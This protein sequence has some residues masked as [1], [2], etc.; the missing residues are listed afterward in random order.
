MAIPSTP[1]EDGTDVAVVTVAPANYTGQADYYCTGVDD[2][3]IINA[4]IEY[5]SEAYG[6]GK[7]QMLEGT[8]NLK[9]GVK[10]Y[11]V[12]VTANVT[13]LGSGNGTRVLS[14]L[15]REPRPLYLI[16]T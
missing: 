9:H 10:I 5:V 15:Y 3:L 8:F 12:L 2:Q 7:V 14:F 1:A 13:L 6:G 16:C 11:G 4:A